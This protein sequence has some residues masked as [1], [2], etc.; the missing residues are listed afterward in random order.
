M[1]GEF[2]STKCCGDELERKQ[3][4]LMK[5]FQKV[6]IGW[7]LMSAEKESSCEL[8][9]NFLCSIGLFPEAELSSN[10]TS[11]SVPPGLPEIHVAKH[12]LTVRLVSLNCSLFFELYCLL[13]YGKKFSNLAHLFLLV[14][15][16]ES[17][18]FCR[19]YNLFQC[20]VNSVIVRM[21]YRDFLVVI[22]VLQRF[23]DRFQDAFSTSLIPKT[24]TGI[25]STCVCMYCS[26]FFYSLQCFRCKCKANSCLLRGKLL[27][28]FFADNLMPNIVH[29]LLKSDQ[30]SLWFLGDFQGSAFPL[31]RLVLTSMLQQTWLCC[32]SFLFF[33]IFI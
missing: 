29:C 18:Y 17:I 19:I 32:F 22:N 21:S 4:P 11:N 28:L 20:D 24:F 31:L 9:N 26:V 15:I 8:T 25:Q 5:T 3:L 7:C 30:I 33:C 10:E 23:A 14:V 12:R 27:S 1:D 6:K 13:C 2:T 16:A